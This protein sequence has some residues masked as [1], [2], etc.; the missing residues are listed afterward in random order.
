[1]SDLPRKPPTDVR[2]QLRREVGFGCPVRGCQSPYLQYHHFDPEWHVEQ[3]HR[4][5]GMIP[6]CAE[7]HGKA[8]AWTPED[9]RKMKEVATSQRVELLGRFEWMRRDVLAIVGGNSYYKTPYVVVAN[10]NPVVWFERDGDDRLLLSVAMITTTHEP[11][12]MLSA[13]D[14]TVLG[15][16]TD[17]ES[18]PNGS[19]FKVKYSNGDMVAVRFRQWADEEALGKVFAFATT[20]IEPLAYPV[21]TC[22]VELAVG[23]TPIKFGPT[24]STL[25]GPRFG[26]NR[27]IGG[28]IGFEFTLPM[29]MTKVR[30]GDVS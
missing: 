27:I 19:S 21:V 24:Y 30:P 10:D 14:W 2:R 5:E 4:P 20:Q 3:H 23:D 6:L 22:E 12:A 1:M 13:N 11:R 7:H 25:G 9:L 26:G 8:A 16:P 18:P 15:D 28:E 17:V 29:T